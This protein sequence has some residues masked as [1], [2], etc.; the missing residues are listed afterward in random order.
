MKQILFA[1]SA[2]I[3]LFAFTTVGGSSRHHIP[4]VKDSYTLTDTTHK[5]KPDSA[6]TMAFFQTVQ[7]DTTHKPK[8]DSLRSLVLF[9]AGVADTTHKPKPDSLRSM[10]MFTT[11]L[12]DTTHKPKPDS[13]M[14]AMR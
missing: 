10:A 3:G 11:V 4:T 12:A 14:I 5:P 9:T 13:L 7:M 6:R 8:P 1:A 2:C